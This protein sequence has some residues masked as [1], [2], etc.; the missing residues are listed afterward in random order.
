MIDIFRYELRKG[1]VGDRIKKERDRSGLTQE[2][3][4]E[5]ITLLVNAEKEVSQ[6]TIAS[7]E[8]GKTLPPL[9]RLIALAD[10][11]GCDIGYLLGD[12]EQRRRD[13]ADVCKVTGLTESA[14]E[15]LQTETAAFLMYPIPKSKKHINILNAILESPYFLELFNNLGYYLIHG[16]G[17]TEDDFTEDAHTL[18]PGEWVEIHK[19]VNSRACIISKQ[20][21][22]REMYLQSAS[23]TLKTMFKEI[24]DQE[25][26]KR[27]KEN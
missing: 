24:L 12:H 15:R 1:M 19:K 18:E 3:L 25:V 26:K 13:T 20:Q 5:K 14:V 2:V 9:G 7:W 16:V 22:I 17:F 4:A 27:G 23:D 10:I 11:F 8:S 6:S 21:D